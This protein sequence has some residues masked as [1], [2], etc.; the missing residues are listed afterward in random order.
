MLSPSL[1]PFPSPFLSSFLTFFLF[2]ETEGKLPGALVAAVHP[3]RLPQAFSA[4]STI[5]GSQTVPELSGVPRERMMS[6]A[7]AWKRLTVE[8]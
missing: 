6:P 1:P 8:S 2:L 4:A 5:N 3:A 7:F